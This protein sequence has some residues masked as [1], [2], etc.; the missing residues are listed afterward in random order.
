MPDPNAFDVNSNLTVVNV[1]NSITTDAFIL[2]YS[3]DA[4][5]M[6]WATFYGGGDN[7]QGTDV[8]HSLI[9]DKDDN[10]YVFG[11]TSA[12]DFPIVN[13]FQST[14]AGGVHCSVIYNWGMYG[15]HGTT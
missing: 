3:P 13:G 1:E 2:K 10:V 9:C 12:T 11:S 6:W 4:T 15:I 8:P 14:H 7:T 5:T